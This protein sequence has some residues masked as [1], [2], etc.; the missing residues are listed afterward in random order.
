MI[1][2]DY[3]EMSITE[4]EIINRVLKKEYVIEDGRIREVLENE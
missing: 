2:T 1:V 4:L 3:N